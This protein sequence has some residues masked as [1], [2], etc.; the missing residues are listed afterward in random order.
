V[1]KPTN[2]RWSHAKNQVCLTYFAGQ[3]LYKHPTVGVNNPAELS[4]LLLDVALLVK[5][6][7]VLRINGVAPWSACFGSVGYISK[8]KQLFKNR[9]HC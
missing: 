1:R 8:A 4:Y 6:W 5:L 2:V 9:C 3:N 7:N